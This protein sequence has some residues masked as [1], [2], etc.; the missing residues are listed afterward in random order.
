MEGTNNAVHHSATRCDERAGN[1]AAGWASLK[2]RG[3]ARVQAKRN[4]FLLAEGVVA[5][6]EPGAGM[7]D[8]GSVLVAAGGSRDGKDPPVPVQLSVA[9]EHYNR[10]ARLLEHTVPVT[11]DLDV[12]SSF[13]DKDLACSTSSP[14]SPAPTRPT[15]S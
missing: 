12:R 15:T 9:T 1:A 5:V 7:G 11:L 8:S 13:Q 3:D 4:A 10:I 2:S 14:K 6:I